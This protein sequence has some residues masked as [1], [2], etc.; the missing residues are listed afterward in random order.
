MTGLPPLLEYPNGTLIPT[1]LLLRNMPDR[2]YGIFVSNLFGKAGATISPKYSWFFT[3]PRE[4]HTLKE[5]NT[6]QQVEGKI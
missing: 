2:A 4:Y 6:R 1:N 3:D 5:F